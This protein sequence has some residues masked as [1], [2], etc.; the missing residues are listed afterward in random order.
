MFFPNLLGASPVLHR[1]NIPTEHTWCGPPVPR[2]APGP[3]RP[4][5]FVIGS[6]ASLRSPGPAQHQPSYSVLPA[7][8]RV[9][10]AMRR[11]MAHVP[12]RSHASDRTIRGCRD[13]HRI[14]PAVGG[15]LLK[16]YGIRPGT[17][18]TIPA[19]PRPKARP[20]LPSPQTGRGGLPIREEYL[21]QAYAAGEG[22]PPPG[23]PLACM[24]LPSRLSQLLLSL[25]LLSLSLS[26]K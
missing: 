25:S 17:I 13:T 2:K 22:S 24:P 5:P 10:A 19:L 3:D 26:P 7:R 16:V 4:V 23:Q 15:N 11:C 18:G 14:P 8:P 21:C 6:T 1:S 20:G 12:P 9:P